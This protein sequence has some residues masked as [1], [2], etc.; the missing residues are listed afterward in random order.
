[1]MSTHVGRGVRSEFDLIPPFLAGSPT[2]PLRTAWIRTV[3][4]EIRRDPAGSPADCCFNTVGR[5]ILT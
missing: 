2:P 4:S 1:M 5:N 3:A